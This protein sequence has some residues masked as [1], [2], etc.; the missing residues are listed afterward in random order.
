L[1]VPLLELIAVPAWRRLLRT[2][3]PIRGRDTFLVGDVDDIDEALDGLRLISDQRIRVIGRMSG[4]FDSAQL[5]DAEEVICVSPHINART[6]LE[7]LRIRGPRGFLML[8]SHADAL[9][10]S[11]MLG[12]IGD[13]P[14]VE[15]GVSC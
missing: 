4:S 3:A 6:R 9:L 8:A 11:R 7:L 2:V 15:V 5:R 14:L 12:W 10:A 13:Q 1:A